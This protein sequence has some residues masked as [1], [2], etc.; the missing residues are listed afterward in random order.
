[1]MNGMEFL[2]S[3]CQVS[4]CIQG[5]VTKLVK[6]LEGISCGVTEDSSSLEKRRLKGDLVA[7]C[8]FLRSGVGSADLF[9]LA[10]C[11]RPYGNGSKMHLGRLR[12]DNRHVIYLR[13]YA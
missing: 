10:S 6:G 7:V 13:E 8:S 9:S 3:K 2:K 5:R 4:E 12:L 11:D 1:M